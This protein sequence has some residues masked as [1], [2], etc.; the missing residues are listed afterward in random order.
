MLITLCALTTGCASHR[1]HVAADRQE[2]NL[3]YVD[4]GS[5]A[6]AFDPPI[7]LGAPRLNLN[8]D[9]CQPQAFVG[10]D[11]TVTTF[12]YVRSDDRQTEDH[13]NDRYERRA[14]SEQFG[15]SYR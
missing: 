1:S 14:I 11:Q 8:R 7:V 13:R 15:T 2:A 9:L 10:F 4:A 6:M 5:P 12:F 3:R